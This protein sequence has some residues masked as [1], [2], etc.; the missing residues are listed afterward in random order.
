MCFMPLSK[1]VTH[2]KSK[3]ISFVTTKANSALKRSVQ[4]QMGNTV[5]CPGVARSYKLQ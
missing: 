1:Y 5:Y 4:L 3:M 2:D